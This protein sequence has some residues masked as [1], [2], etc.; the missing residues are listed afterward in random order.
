[1]IGTIARRLVQGLIVIAVMSLVVFFLIGLMPGDPVDLLASADPRMTPGEVARLRAL[2]GLDQPVWARYL[3]WAGHAAQ[4][5]FGYSRAFA[6]PVVTL[7]VERLGATLILMVSS[8]V[9][10]SAAGIVFGIAAARRPGG[11]LDGLIRAGAFVTIA[12]PGFWLALM[13]MAL[14]AVQLGWLPATALPASPNPTWAERARHL[15]LPVATLAIVQAGEIARF[16]RAAMIEALA[17]DHI[18]T[19]RAKGASPARVLWRH[20]LRGAMIPIV[21]IMALGFGG[22]FSGALITETIFAYPGMGKLIYDALVGNDYNLA[23]VGLLFATATTLAANL[24]ADLA[25]VALDPR[26]TLGDRQ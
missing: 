20:A 13:L 7:L 10:A 22:L 8:F 4:G 16:A 17:A 25:Y 15:I 1:M 6:R 26:I 5:D 11:V 12:T 23:L 9:I 3:A 18:R 19:A 21:T 24:I 2:Y 14:F